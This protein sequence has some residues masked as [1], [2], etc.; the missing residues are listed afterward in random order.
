[1]KGWTLEDYEA[2][3]NRKPEDKAIHR[4]SQPAV[5]SELKRHAVLIGIDTGTKTGVAI[6][7]EGDFKIIETLTIWRALN[8]VKE[9]AEYHGAKNVFVRVEDA[10]Q[11]TWFG[12]TGKERLKGAGSVERDCAIWEEVLTDLGI[13]F[14]MVHPK[15]V[16]ETK[17]DYFAKITGWSGRTSK[18]SREAAWLIL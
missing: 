16:K 18:H 17:P 9:W 7:C 6:K 3:Q 2:F 8:L 11:R 14:E 10:R 5:L 15:S 12:E 4:R 1:M 13:P